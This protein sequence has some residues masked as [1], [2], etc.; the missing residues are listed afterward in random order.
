MVASNHCNAVLIDLDGTM[1]DTAPDIAA[2]VTCMLA[3][4][5]VAPLSFDR[6][7]GFI[8]NGVPNLVRRSLE[9]AGIEKRVAIERALLVFEQH[10]ANTNG[11]VGRVFPGVMDGLRELRKR[12]YRSACVTNKPHALAAPLLTNTGLAAYLDVLV[13]GDTIASMKPSPEPLW[14]ACRLLDADPGRCALVGDSPVD[15]AAA[16]AAGLP[17]FIVKYGYAGQGGADAL[18]C[19][20]LID[21]FE[22]LP[23]ILAAR[24]LMTHA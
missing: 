4:F 16:R 14:H 5:G 12:G 15:V 20:G 24:G 21:S 3:D 1:V 6:V 18:H 11:R 8:G 19:D 10:Y 7:T 2:A 13:A 17:V 22:A 9:A 23:A